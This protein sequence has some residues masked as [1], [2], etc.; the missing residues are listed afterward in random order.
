[1]IDAKRISTMKERLGDAVELIDDEQYLPMY[2]NRQIHY[3]ELFE[4]S[5]Q[6]ARKKDNP[7]RYFAA[8]WGAKTLSKTLDWL[9]KLM[10]IAS[11]KLAEIKR[12]IQQRREERKATE[13]LQN[14][15]NR[16]N[17]RRLEKMMR[18][19]KLFEGAPPHLA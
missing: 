6:L 18:S 17:R 1:M 9:Q 8:L 16:E 19:S 2:R 14:P 13:A 15:M 10:N 3:P 5:K 11:S 4:F 12:G 7:A